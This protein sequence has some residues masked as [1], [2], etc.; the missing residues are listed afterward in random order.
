MAK[1]SINDSLGA[2]DSMH[3]PAQTLCRALWYCI[4]SLQ[5]FKSVHPVIALL[6]IYHKKIGDAHQNIICNNEKLKT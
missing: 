6:E 1:L 4:K 2:S 3:K 5:T